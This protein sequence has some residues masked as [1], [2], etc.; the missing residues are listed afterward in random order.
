MRIQIVAV[1]AAL[2]MAGLAARGAEPQDKLYS[3][4]RANDLRQIKALLVEGAGANAA[5]PDG[6]TPLMV[7][8]EIGSVDAMKTLIDQQA[9]V[10]AKNALGATALMWS[11]TDPK[12]VR[13]LLDHGADV[14]VTARSGRTAL[15][16]ASF[17]N[18]SAEVVRMLLAGGAKVDVM[19]QRKVTP[20][21]AA[22]FGN[23]TG[24]VRLLLDAGADVNTADTF[25]GLTPLIN[26]SG[27][28]NLEAVKLL[29]AKGANVNAVSK[30]QNL[31]RIQ[32]GIVEFGGWTPLL[33]A[34]PFGPPDIL[35][36]LISAGANV[37]VQD[38]RGF[39]PLMLAAANDH[40]NPEIVR[41]LLKHNADREPKTRAGETLPDWVS[42][43]GDPAVVRAAGTTAKA[44]PTNISLSKEPPDIR[45]AVQRS[46]SLLERTTTQ[47][48]SRG[49]CFSCHEQPPAAFAVGAARGKG[50]TIDE[51][52][53]IERWAQ[54]TAGLKADQLEG[55]AP[56]G[57]ADNNL[58]LAEALIRSGYAPD[59]KTDILAA[60]L[61]AYQGGDGGWHLPGYA[62]SPLQDND[63]SRTAMAIRAL[64]TY[65]TPGRA[66]EMK[67]RIDRAK[68]WLL[69]ATPVTT[70]DF[71]MRLA[72]VA[73]A[74]ATASE[75]RK[76]AEPL[77]ARQ[78]PD[79]G[80]AQRDGF[81]SDA[82]ATGMTLWALASAG[83]VRPGDDVYRNGVRFLLGTQAADGSWH[84]TSRA[85]KFQIYF[86]S[87]FP[88]GH[89]QWIST[90]ATGWAASALSQA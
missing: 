56:L 7:A 50:I 27:N 79:G 28:R 70:E 53:A 49:A 47:F 26:A 57:G 15:I 46:V 78:R 58:Y 87:G 89:D 25:I 86:E 51:P 22:T 88:Y 43:F 81:S 61:A 31:P 45:T 74:G 52:A 72:G 16:I 30:T 80:F 4:I 40:A 37:S 76:L 21:N 5:G 33:M 38:Y 1:C 32:T 3:A 71:D 54:I 64:K 17:A 59:T 20:L 85:T 12:K 90:M 73:A 18:P 14:N 60:N 13:L 66:A 77:L 36:T 29:L 67:E 35:E 11:G 2:S 23:D 62:R 39:T 65:G 69:H 44:A 41:L 63:F 83:V 75:L 24:T 84:V 9:D 68:Q 8:A 10:N 19:D 55:A 48:Y 82:Y 34:A 6:V 42:R